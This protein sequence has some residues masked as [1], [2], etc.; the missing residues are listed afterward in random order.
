[1]APE[2][3]L[4]KPSVR[5][6]KAAA[7]PEESLFFVTREATSEGNMRALDLIANAARQFPMDSAIRK[8][9][10]AI[11]AQAKKDPSIL[12]KMVSSVGVEQIA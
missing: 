8:E 11:K 10:D 1:M 4:Q 6:G 5:I 7:K 3:L 9:I 12:A 2:E